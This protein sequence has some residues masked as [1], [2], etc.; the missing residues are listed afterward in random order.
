M[1]PSESPVIIVRTRRYRGPQQ[2]ALAML[3]PVFSVL[4]AVGLVGLIAYAMSLGPRK[5]MIVRK[6]TPPKVVTVAP[7]ESARP[8]PQR[9]EGRDARQ[10]RHVVYDKSDRREQTSPTP[11]VR[12]L[13]HTERADALVIESLAAAREGLFV[14]ANDLAQEAIRLCPE[15]PA[16]TGAWYLAAYA[17]QY[18]KLA[19][20]AM[21][22]LNGDVDLGP[23]YGIAAFIERNG[24]TY[25]F[26]CR[27]GNRK[28]TSRQLGAMNGVRFRI[29]RQFLD[30]AENPANE[31]ILAAVHYLKRIDTSGNQNLTNPAASLDAAVARCTNATRGAD[32]LAEHA[33]HV[34]ALFRWLEARPEVSAVASVD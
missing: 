32:G 28:F 9:G 1:H 34:M 31:L 26:R 19:D 22:R 10:V 18:P 5:P 21:E 2:S 23:K 12:S 20:E 29:T 17:Q 24:D 3:M 6:V 15:H 33:E 7:R 27:G 11:V 13:D 4:W 8:L 14:K 30:N 16:A 25:T